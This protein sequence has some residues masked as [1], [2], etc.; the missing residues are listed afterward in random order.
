MKY[1]PIKMTPVYKDYIWGGD[2][3]KTHWGKDDCPYE[4]CAESWELSGHKNGESCAANGY[5][6]GKSL[7]E[8]I[9]TWGVEALGKKAQG[10][11]RFPVLIKLIDAQQNLSIQV[12]PDDSFALKNEGEYGKTEM[13]YVAQANEGSG[14]L[15]G[16]K[17]DIS[18][19]EY[20]NSIANNSLTELLNFVPVKKGDVLFLSPGTVHAICA[21]VVIAEI[22]QN[23]DITYRVYDYARVGADGNPRALHIDK[24][25]MVSNLK[26]QSFDGMPQ[27]TPL[28]SDG[29]TKTLLTSCDYF[30]AYEI[31]TETEF[32]GF[33]R[34]DSFVALTFID[35][36]GKLIYGTESILYKKGDTFFIPAA[37]GEYIIIGKSTALLTKL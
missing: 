28:S 25:V 27:G 23:S 33:A 15:C 5:L 34:Q 2:R 22:Q 7:N 8:I 37:F 26:A 36:D 35:G 12:H 9:N 24:A 21:G 11:E 29:F 13:W 20:Q 14:L 3:L 30:T 10:C 1:Y 32:R 18:P 4:K 19:A 31:K 16:F 17:R 6:K